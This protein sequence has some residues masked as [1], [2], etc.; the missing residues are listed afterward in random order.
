[1]LAR[2][3]LDGRA[4]SLVLAM[5]ATGRTHQIRVHM[6]YIGHALL[7]DDKYQRNPLAAKVN[8]LCLHAWQLSLAD[9]GEESRPSR[10]GASVPTDFGLLLPDDWLDKLNS[11]LPNTAK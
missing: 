7:G 11:Q 2:F 9:D 1:M 6:A 10:F 8:R 5:P 4:V 3:T